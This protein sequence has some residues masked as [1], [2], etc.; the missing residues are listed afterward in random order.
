MKGL[1]VLALAVAATGC[2]T[3]SPFRDSCAAQLRSGAITYVEAGFSDRHVERLG[4]A[5]VTT[6]AAAGRRRPATVTTWSFRGYDPQR[7]VGVRDHGV[8]RVFVADDLDGAERQRIMDRRLLN[9]G[10][11]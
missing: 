4:R 5:Q 1:V 9:A 2:G 3:K 10:Q 7:V 8:Y 6:C 11:D